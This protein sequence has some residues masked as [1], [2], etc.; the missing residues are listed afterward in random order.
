MDIYNFFYDILSKF[1]D[2]I[3]ILK[4]NDF[5]CNGFSLENYHPLLRL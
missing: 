4:G 2:F 3:K 1:Y 5:D